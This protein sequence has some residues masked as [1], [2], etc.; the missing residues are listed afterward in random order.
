MTVFEQKLEVGSNIRISEVQALLTFSI[1]QEWDKIIEN[2]RKIAERYM[3]IC[4]NTGIKYIS[5]NEC[6]HDGNYYKFI[7]YNNDQK[8][9]EAFPHLKTKTSQVYDYE[10]GVTNKVAD[11]HMCLPIWYGLEKEVVDKVIDEFYD[12]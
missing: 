4:K 2:K 7:I 3:R 1:I 9:T 8:I 6:G 12:L 5:Q 11:Y 10:I